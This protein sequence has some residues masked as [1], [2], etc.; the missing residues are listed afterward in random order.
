VT[1]RRLAD[2][3]RVDIETAT[4]AVF[5]RRVLLDAIVPLQEAADVCAR[6]SAVYRRQDVS[7]GH[8]GLTS[9]ASELRGLT[10]LVAMLTGPLQID[11]GTS[12][13]DGTTAADEMETLGVAIDA[14][15]SAQESE[16]WLTVA[17]VLEYDLDPAIRRWI[18]LL[19]AVANRV[20]DR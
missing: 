18:D 16:D 2:V 12:A 10:V 11:L 9:L 8:A 13:S 3:A 4:P 5:L 7:A 1:A 20:P 19:T 15:V 14:L 17:D 6:L